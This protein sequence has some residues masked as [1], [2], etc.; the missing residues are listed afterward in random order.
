MATEIVKLINEGVR[1]L[2]NEFAAL[3][4]SARVLQDRL[5]LPDN[6]GD[7]VNSLSGKEPIDD[8]AVSDGRPIATPENIKLFLGAINNFLLSMEDNN[9]TNLHAVLA[10]SSRY[11]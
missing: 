10:L 8:G 9:K 6:I 1:P 5:E 3:Y 7:L 4:Y 11:K 2:A